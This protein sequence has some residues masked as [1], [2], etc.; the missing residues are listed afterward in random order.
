V[1]ERNQRQILQRHSEVVS[2][3]VLLPSS[4]GGREKPLDPEAFRRKVRIVEKEHG[5]LCAVFLE[6]LWKR[7]LCCD[8]AA[9]SKMTSTQ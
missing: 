1:S 7:E 6:R 4:W 2:D 3:I 9:V 5:E 8:Q